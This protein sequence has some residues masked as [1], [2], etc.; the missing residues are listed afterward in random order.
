MPVSSTVLKLV[1]IRSLSRLLSSKTLKPSGVTARLPCLVVVIKVFHS[2]LVGVNA[3]PKK[4]DSNIFSSPIY[5]FSFAASVK[6]VIPEASCSSCRTPSFSNLFCNLSTG[7]FSP[8][9]ANL[10]RASDSLEKN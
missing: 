7:I 2:L 3:D 10:E 5:L 9:S 8:L 4:S 6:L 1:L